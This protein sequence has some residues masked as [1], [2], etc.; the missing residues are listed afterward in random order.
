MLPWHFVARSIRAS[1]KGTCNHPWL[2]PTCSVRSFG[3]DAGSPNSHT[4]TCKSVYIT[5]IDSDSSNAPLLIG[6]M[7]YFLRHIPSIGF[8]QPIGSTR[9]SPGSHTSAPSHADLLHAA[10]PLKGSPD[11]SVGVTQQEAVTRLAAGQVEDL[12]EDIYQAYEKYR[13]PFDVVLMEGATQE[14]I[15]SNFMEV[16]AEVCVV[17]GALYARRCAGFLLYDALHCIPFCFV[18]V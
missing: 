17:V 12:M 15:G 3:N 1:R 16:N 13:A 7:D 11:S 14:M 5:N 4:D 18:H 8:F 2:R 9:T 6:L 10:F